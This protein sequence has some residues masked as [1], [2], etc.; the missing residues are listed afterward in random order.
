MPFEAN[1]LRP[2]EFVWPPGI[3]ARLF[4]RGLSAL[5]LRMGEIELRE[6]VAVSWV[7]LTALRGCTEPFRA[8][9][10]LWTLGGRPLA[11]GGFFC[12]LSSSLRAL[13]LRYMPVLSFK[14][15]RLSFI[16]NLVPAA[17]GSRCF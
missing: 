5:L 4:I 3:H 9:R 16:E 2:R 11:G 1:L 14:L 10:G 6:L 15:M 13:E 17:L 8:G 12:A 7:L